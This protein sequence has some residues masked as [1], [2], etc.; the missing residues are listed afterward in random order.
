[1][2]YTFILVALSVYLFQKYCIILLVDLILKFWDIQDERT[3]RVF[4]EV[5]KMSGYV[6]RQV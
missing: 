4:S 1:M 2:V 3:G 6:K 5:R